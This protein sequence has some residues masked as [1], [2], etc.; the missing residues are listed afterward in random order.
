MKRDRDYPEPPKNGRAFCAFHNVH[1]H[2]T[3]DCQ[4]LRALYEGHVIQRP[5]RNSRG[6]GRGGCRNG[7]RWDDRRPH[8]EWRDR[9]REDHW[10]DQPCEGAWRDQPREDRPQGNTGLPLLPPPPRRKGDHHQDEGA[11]GFQEPRAIACILG[12]AR[13][14]ASQRIFKQFA[15]EVN[16]TLPR[17]KATRPLR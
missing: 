12:G 16:A 14:L 10:Q 5:E 13:A 11:R 15:R 6:Y 1:S 3:H 2:N 17:L 7:G 4:E 8:Q 9:P